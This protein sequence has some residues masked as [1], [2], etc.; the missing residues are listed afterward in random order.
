VVTIELPHAQEMPNEAEVERI[1]RD[2]LSWTER[3]VSGQKL[4]AAR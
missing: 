3:S 2:M 4:A 1:W